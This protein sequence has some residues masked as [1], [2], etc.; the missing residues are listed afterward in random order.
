MRRLLFVFAFFAVFSTRAYGPTS[1]TWNGTAYDIP[2][3]GELNW[4]DLS[5][6][7]IDVGNNAQTTNFQKVA[8]RVATTSPVT[9]AAATDFLVV[10]DLT[11]A[12]AVAVD[13]PAGV[14]GQIFVITDGKGDAATNNVT[15]DGN[16]AETI[17]GAATL[18]MDK[19]RQSVI[20]GWS[21]SDWNILGTY[22][23]TDAD[24]AAHAALTTGVHGVTGTVVGTSDA[25]TLT[26]KTIDAD[27]NTVSNIDDG[28]IKAAAAIARSKLASGTASHVIINDGSGVMS[29]EA[30]LAI[31]RGGTGAATATAA[32]DALSPTT[33]KG[34]IIVDNG[35]NDIRLAVG[36]DGQALV[37]DSVEAS[38]IK[39]GNV[40]SDPTTTRGELIRRGAAALEAF[41]AE[42]DN[43][44]VRGDGTDVVSGQIDDPDFFTTGAA[45]GSGAIGIVTTGAQTFAG[46][47]TFTGSIDVD[48]NGNIDGNLVVDGKTNTF[49]GTASS[50]IN[51]GTFDTL[52]NAN[53]PQTSCFM[54]YVWA[55]TASAGEY[56]VFHIH[57]PVT[58]LYFIRT[59]ISASVTAGIA[60]SNQ[61]QI[62][63]NAGATRN[64]SWSA[65][66]CG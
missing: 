37:A 60:G 13:L 56:G 2:L 6:F 22:V 64:F 58:G 44:V 59:V 26:N 1:V 52:T 20:L 39:W 9:V 49:E 19:N 63:N 21:G 40:A 34:D 11:V 28:E 33:T 27:S 24:I 42:T 29:S 57:R 61:V 55:T 47:K 18:V 50:V 30:S 53:I 62:T 3:A 14:T 5:S 43:R 36:G 15:I 4:S 10:S 35:T 65:L 31:S 45:A 16:L 17:N 38:G 23:D 48:T 41:A 32:F 51:G 8:A 46:D 7:L 12:G 25:Q 66:R 54:L